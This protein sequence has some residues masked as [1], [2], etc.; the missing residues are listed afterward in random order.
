MPDYVLNSSLLIYRN[1]K[2]NPKF[3]YF[4]KLHVDNIYDYV[5]HY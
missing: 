2:Q 1:V 4:P 5:F 3:H